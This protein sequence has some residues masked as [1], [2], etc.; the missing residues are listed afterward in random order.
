MLDEILSIRADR[1]K[2]YCGKD[3]LFR[4]HLD[5][6]AVLCHT[7]RQLL[8]VLLDGLMWESNQ[9]VNGMKRV[10]YFVRDLYGNPFM[11]R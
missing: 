1:N 3:D 7:S 11:E 2:Y 4:V 5:L 8:F 6:V 9:V 10:N